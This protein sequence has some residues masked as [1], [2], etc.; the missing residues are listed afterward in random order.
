[1][2]GP[3]EV[4]T[5][6]RGR[7]QWICTAV[8]VGLVA[9]L[10]ASVARLYHPPVRLHRDDRFCQPRH[11]RTAGAAGDPPLPPSSLG[12]LRRPVLR[13]ARARA[14]LARS[15]DRRGPRPGAVSRPPHPLQLERVGT[16]TRPA[17]VDP[18]GVRAPERAL[19]ADPRRR[20]DAMAAAR[21]AARPRPVDGVPLLARIAALGAVGAAR[22]TEH[23][24]HCPRHRR[25]RAWAALHLCR[26]RRR[27]RAWT[28]DEPARHV[29]LALARRTS[30]GG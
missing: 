8:V 25:L 11:R 23:A 18:P 15:R 20:H 9:L 5:A 27:G 14:A 24:P 21:H 6:G 17:G 16:R 22:R 29:R 7:S 13:P 30:A 3:A 26:H 10:L 28:R 4:T 12:K 2:T 1:M 19:L